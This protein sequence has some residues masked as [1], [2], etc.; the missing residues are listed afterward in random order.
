METWK[1]GKWIVGKK[2]KQIKTISTERSSNK[3]KNK[4]T[5]K[6]LVAR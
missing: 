6:L 4:V 3:R 2:T 5:K 1:W